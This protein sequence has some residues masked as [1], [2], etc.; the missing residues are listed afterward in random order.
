MYV[1]A[2]RICMTYGDRKFM[3]EVGIEPCTLD[4]RF[5]RPLPPPLPPGPVI[6]SLTEKDACWLQNL[7]VMRE[8][9]PEPGFKPPKSLREYLARYPSGIREATEEAAKSLDLNLPSGDLDA[10]AQDVITM[11]L[12]FCPDLEDIVEMYVTFRL[13]RP[14]EDRSGHFHSYVKMRVKAALLTLLGN[15]GA[16]ER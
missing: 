8:Q 7:G 5:P 9:D 6:P 14:R 16:G 15:M 13:I 11:F 4:D 12:G 2:G 10:L 3:M 1:M